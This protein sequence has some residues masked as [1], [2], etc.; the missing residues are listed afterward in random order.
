MNCT[1]FTLGPFQT[2]CYLVEHHDECWII[3]ASFEPEPMIEAIRS[4]GLTPVALLL[5]HAHVDHIAGIPAVREAF[6][7]LPIHLHAAEHGWLQAPDLNLSA[8]MGVPVTTPPADHA[9]ED[10]QTLHLGDVAWTV[11]HTPG[12]SPGG[13]T[14]HQ[15]ES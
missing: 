3:D 8:A 4:R 15:A 7:D 10:G 1:P 9:L 11:L 2:N 13:V 5:T 6:P 14:F 12:H